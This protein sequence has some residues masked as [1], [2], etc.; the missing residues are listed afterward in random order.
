MDGS[1]WYLK[2]CDLFEQL[3][4]PQA[5]R[6][7]RSA[8]VRAFPRNA[9]VYAP[10]EPGLSVLVVAEGRV[11]IKDVTPDGK[12]TILAFLEPGEIFGE[13]AVMDG[14]PRQEYAEAIVDSRILVL[15]RDE[16]LW[17]LSARPDVAFS[18]TKL[19][20]LRRQR[21]EG[22]LRNLLFLSSRDRMIHMLLELQETHGDRAGNGCR[23]RLPLSHQDLAGL[24][25][26]TRE[27][28]TVVLGRLRAERLIR[29]ERRRI[30][31]LDSPRLKALVKGDG[32]PSPSAEPRGL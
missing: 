11:K 32:R 16:L 22:R 26:V 9:L 21:V 28:A 13:L 29:V 6:L 19:I 31:I 8:R 1:L 15:P 4:P 25:G 12:E 7:D 27:T 5:E 20:G 17:L 30:T 23:I 24:I 10:T 14:R 2:Q 3:T 18:F